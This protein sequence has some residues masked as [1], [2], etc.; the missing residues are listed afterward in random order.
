MSFK[1]FF[2]KKDENIIE[3]KIEKSE[4]ILD[5]IREKFKIKRIVPT[6]F[7]IEIVFFNSREAEEASKI[8]GTSKVDGTSIFLDS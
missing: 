5:K 2:D 8:A 7:G 1:S 4:D 3:N 6:R